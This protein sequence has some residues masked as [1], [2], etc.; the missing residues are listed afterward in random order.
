MSRPLRTL[1][2]AAG[3]LCIALALVV[4]VGDA[5]ASSRG[6]AVEPK[7]LRLLLLSLAGGALL[8]ASRRAG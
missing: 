1:L 5:L 2:L 8:S 7:F 3:L 6:E 4:V